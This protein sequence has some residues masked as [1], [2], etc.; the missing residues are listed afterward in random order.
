MTKVNEFTVV[1]ND[2]QCNRNCVFIERVNFLTEIVKCRKN[3]IKRQSHN[4]KSKKWQNTIIWAWKI[5][6][7]KNLQKERAPD[8]TL[9][10]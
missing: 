1:S 4:Q 3:G 5:S 9:I 6:F 10:F 8:K 7:P 2:F